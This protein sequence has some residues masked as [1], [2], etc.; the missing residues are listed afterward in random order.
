MWRVTNKR[1]V[2]P[3]YRACDSSFANLISECRL[4]LPQSNI[5]LICICMCMYV[6]M[7]VYIYTH[8]HT[9]VCHNS[10]IFI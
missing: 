7:Y 8:T 3:C 1:G 10:A 2:A 5:V 6:C 9:C 4:P